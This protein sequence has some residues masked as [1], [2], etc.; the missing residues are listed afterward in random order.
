M[1]DRTWVHGLHSAEGSKNWTRVHVLSDAEAAAAVAAGVKTTSCRPDHSLEPIRAAVPDAV[2]STGFP[3]GS[4]SPPQEAI[5]EGLA[6]L[7]R[8]ASAV[9]CSCST[10]FVEATARE[11]IQ[12]TGR[13]GLVP[14]R[15]A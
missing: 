14:N 3:H 8:G 13:G 5:R 2:I 9:H 1:D 15:A 12:V 6:K 11:G 7:A 10:Q 4:V